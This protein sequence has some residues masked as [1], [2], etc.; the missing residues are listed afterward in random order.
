MLENR[1][2]DMTKI[3]GKTFTESMF[4]KFGGPAGGEAPG[5]VLRP[6]EVIVVCHAV[7]RDQEGRGR[8][9]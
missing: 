5:K 7:N 4:V 2:S 3:C 1:F 9:Y 6:G 8:V